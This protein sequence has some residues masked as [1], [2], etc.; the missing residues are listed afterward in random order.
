MVRETAYNEVFDAQRHF[1]SILDSL[2]RPGRI[3]PLDPV[4]LDPPPG[5]NH[6][7][8]LVAL[9]LMDSDVTFHAVHDE[10]GESAYLAANTRAA[11]VPLENAGF[12]FAR[13]ADSPEILES[14]DCGSLPYPDTSASLIL[15][16]EAASAELLAGG[17]RLKFEGP[18][19]DGSAALFARGLNPDLLLA[20]LARNAEF[21]LGIDTVLTF[22]G[23]S[24]GPCVVGV[25]RTARISW[26]QV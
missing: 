9:A 20:L 4:K 10:H 12:I 15:E 2:A 5:L 8:V 1:R 24:G 14:A 7:S 19:V 6:A 23:D 22:A 11:S 25:P 26:E 17:L 18:G 13:G 3:C 21:P 16:L